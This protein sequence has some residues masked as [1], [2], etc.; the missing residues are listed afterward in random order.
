MITDWDNTVFCMRWINEIGKFGDLPR[1]VFSV[2]IAF[3]L[4]KAISE[5]MPISSGLMKKSV[6]EYTEKVVI[7]SFTSK[8][9]NIVE[10]FH[11]LNCLDL[12]CGEGYLGRYLNILGANYLGIDGSYSLIEAAK[13]YEKEKKLQFEIANLDFFDYC[14]KGDPM[15]NIFNLFFNHNKIDIIFFHSILE[16]LKNYKK[17]FYHFT[18]WMVLN[19]PQ[20]IVSLICLDKQFLIDESK[21]FNKLECKNSSF[22]YSLKVPF[23]NNY[24]KV[25][26][27]SE[28]DI[29]NLIESNGFKIIDE[30]NFTR[31]LFTSPILSLLDSKFK[32]W[33]AGG[34]FRA[35]L[36]T[37]D[38]TLL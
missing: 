19:C 6:L 38:E 35:Y 29:R 2:P 16:H 9:T 37:L 26:F 12:G 34:P 20:A 18:N 21:S 33:T 22:S 24:V 8:R 4:A 7:E 10:P 30:L 15:Y 27:F 23:I 5:K 14:A 13:K 11:G 3:G 28:T 31:N 36:L 1:R 25:N 32:K 17:F